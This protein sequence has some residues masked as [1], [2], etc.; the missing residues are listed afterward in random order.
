[1]AS[2]PDRGEILL[3]ELQVRAAALWERRPGNT[4]GRGDGGR[5]VGDAT[6]RAPSPLGVETRGVSDRSRFS[7]P[8]RGLP[9]AL[10]GHRAEGPRPRGRGRVLAR[11]PSRC[12]RP[13]LPPSPLPNSF[14]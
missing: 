14:E 1:M 2:N 9:R 11:V 13:A 5:G 12:H 4:G 8:G 3:T 6:Q 10:G 7:A